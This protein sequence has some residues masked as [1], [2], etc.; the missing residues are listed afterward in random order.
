L[1]SG[2]GVQVADHRDLVVPTDD[3]E[4]AA[5]LWVGE[6]GIDV[7]CTCRRCRS[8]LTRR[9]V[10]DRD[11]PRQFGEPTHRLLMHCG[12]RTSRRKRGREDRNAISR[13]GL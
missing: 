1:P 11:Q 9:C 10:L 5:D 8:D 4:D 6:G 2:V 3:G 13:P 7:G 12:K